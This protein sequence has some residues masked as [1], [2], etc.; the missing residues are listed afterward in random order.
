MS[1]RVESTTVSWKLEGGSNLVDAD[2]QPAPLGGDLAL[3]GLGDLVGEAV[4]SIVELPAKGGDLALASLEV[5][6][7]DE[8]GAGVWVHRGR[9]I[10]RVRVRPRKSW[11]GV[12]SIG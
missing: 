12:P 9:R 4:E 3:V 11:L 8:Q 6:Q 1:A 2:V 5:I 10:V 7:L